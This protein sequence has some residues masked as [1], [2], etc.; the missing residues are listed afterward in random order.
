M[1]RPNPTPTFGFTL[2]ELLIVVAIISILAAIAVPNFQLAN[3][4]ALK[5]RGASNLRTVF[6]ALAMYRIDHNRFPPA[7]REAG[8]FPSHMGSFSA[9]GNGPA[10]GGSWDGVPWL[11]L[12]QGYLTNPEV[13][14]SPRYLRLFANGITI[15]GGQPL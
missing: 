6:G 11:L 8:P 3:D 2:I 13:L 14:F 9:T 7:D 1:I 12:E 15:R 10:G 4:R 5:A